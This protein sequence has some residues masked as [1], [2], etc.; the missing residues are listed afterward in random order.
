MSARDA[1]AQLRW[2]RVA[3]AWAAAYVSGFVLSVLVFQALV[4][5][6]DSRAMSLD[7]AGT[8][9]AIVAGVLMAVVALAVYRPVAGD[10]WWHWIVVG[11]GLHLLTTALNALVMV[12]GTPATPAAAPRFT[13]VDAAV[14]L[15]VAGVSAL[16]GRVAAARVEPRTV[17]PAAPTTLDQ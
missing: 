13:L 1:L 2:A 8:I 14:L 16:W 15:L 4:W 11:V 9:L 17:H 12:L 7:T 3:G 10:L 5:V 6:Q